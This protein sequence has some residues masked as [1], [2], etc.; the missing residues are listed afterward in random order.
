MFDAKSSRYPNSHTYPNSHR[1]F[2][3]T[4]MWLFGDTTVW[5]IPKC[6]TKK[7]KAVEGRGLY[8]SKFG[9]Y[10]VPISTQKFLS[11][12][13]PVTIGTLNF[14]FWLVPG[15]N[16]YL[17]F[18]IWPVFGTHWY[19]KKFSCTYSV[20]RSTQQYQRFRQRFDFSYL[21]GKNNIFFDFG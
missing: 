5:R 6:H 15:T 14:F 7:M 1:F 21:M 11:R 19:P 12:R 3:L 16:W 4:K 9:W 17:E 2:D 13:Y 8:E 18:F 20:Y 10:P